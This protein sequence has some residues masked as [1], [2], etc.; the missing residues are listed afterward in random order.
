MD[1]GD[2]PAEAA[3]RER[4]R[5]WLRA[6]IPPEPEVDDDASWARYRIDWHRRLYDAGW[7]GLSWPAEYG[8]QGLDEYYELILSEEL[9]RAGAPPKPYIGYLGR[10]VM[11]HGS[12]TQ[13]RTYLPGFLSGRDR[14]CQGFSEPGAGSDLASLRTRADQH[15]DGFTITGQKIW[16]SDAMWADHCLLL[17][18]TDPDAPAHAGLSAFMVDMRAEG[19]TVRP[20]VQ[21]TGS[22]EFCEVFLDGVHVHR[23]DLIGEPGAGWRVAMT[24]FE[25]E[26]RPADLGFT[27]TY[28]RTLRRLESSLA[29]PAP[30]GAKEELARRFVDISVLQSY[31][32]WRLSNTTDS[33]GA[34]DRGFR[35]SIDKLLMTTTEQELE[36]TEL[37]L[38]GEGALTGRRPDALQRYLW[39]RAASI[40]GGT[41]QIQKNIVAQRILG[42]PRI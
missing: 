14:W 13:S 20:I 11:E 7:M 18:R 26:R 33:P 25:A 37:R 8:G 35:S 23:D 30:D 34:P 31:L 19:V 3:F 38:A 24:A 6:N 32:R 16:T 22:R 4:L 27:A 2:S 42:L 39:S 36:R 15:G 29:D 1:F 12:P 9:G 5:T 21:I 28:V 40:M 10:A 41:E 17:A